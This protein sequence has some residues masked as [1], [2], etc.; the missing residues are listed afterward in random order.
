V[1]YQ[2]NTP[3]CRAVL[4]EIEPIDRVER[5]QKRGSRHGDRMNVGLRRSTPK[6]I[7]IASSTEEWI[8]QYARRPA[9]VIY[10]VRR[11]VEQFEIEPNDEISRS[12]DTV[13]E[14]WS[15]LCRKRGVSRDTTDLDDGQCI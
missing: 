4:T 10:Q 13:T 6:C 8:K 1:I 14:I 11:N 15:T 12:P 5:S 7:S 2:G 9:F 3:K